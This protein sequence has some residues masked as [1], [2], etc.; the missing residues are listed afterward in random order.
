VRLLIPSGTYVQSFRSIA[1][2]VTKRA[3]LTD[4]DHVRWR[5]TSVTFNS[6][7]NQKPVYYVMKPY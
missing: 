6:R 3:M 1:I 4:D 7:S 2:A 5:L